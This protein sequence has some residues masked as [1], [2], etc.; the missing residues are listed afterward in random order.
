GEIIGH[1][2][3]E[4]ELGLLEAVVDVIGEH[5]ALRAAREGGDLDPLAP[6]RR[7]VGRVSRRGRHTDDQRDAHGKPGFPGAVNQ[8][9]IL[10]FGHLVSKALSTRVQPTGCSYRRRWRRAATAKTAAPAERKADRS[11]REW[12]T[13]G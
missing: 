10:P 1:A 13:R 2:R 6:F 7:R 9:C 5:A 4:I 11:N 12:R 3:P 8:H